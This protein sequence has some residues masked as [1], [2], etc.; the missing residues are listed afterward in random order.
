MVG[1][2]SVALVALMQRTEI[3]LLVSAM[4]QM[5]PLLWRGRQQERLFYGR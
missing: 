2:S 1:P 5:G 4:G 3:D